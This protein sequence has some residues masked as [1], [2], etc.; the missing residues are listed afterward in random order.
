MQHG[1]API[2]NLSMLNNTKY[3][4]LL[5]SSSSTAIAE[6]LDAHQLK[7]KFPGEHI[8]LV[9]SESRDII[10][11]L[12]I[13][14]QVH[15]ID[16]EF[17][18]KSAFSPLLGDATSFKVL[19][20]TLMPLVQEKWARIFNLSCERL[21]TSVASLFGNTPVL[22]A[23]R[24]ENITL[25]HES[26]LK[27]SSLLNQWGMSHSLID[28]FLYRKAL[29]QID[30]SAVET[31][32]KK[33]YGY[34]SAHSRGDLKA[35]LV[36]MSLSNNNPDDRASIE[37]IGQLFTLISL[38]TKTSDILENYGL[39]YIDWSDTNPDLELFL[40]MNVTDSIQMAKDW[41][42]SLNIS[43]KDPDELTEKIAGII[44][45]NFSKWACLSFLFDYLGY[46][47]LA[48]GSEQMITR[49]DKN[50]LAP[51]LHQDVLALKGF[52]KILLEGL[53]RQGLTNNNL[54]A[55]YWSQNPGTLSFICAIELSLQPS[56]DPLFRNDHDVMAIK[57]RL[58]SLNHFFEKMH[59]ACT[60]EMPT[61]DLA[62]TL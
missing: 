10:L 22:G 16:I 39:N 29:N 6:G 25:C 13:F 12:G 34:K 38:D 27:L 41:D 35:I 49:Y 62:L 51:F 3:L 26:P 58:R 9:R 8:A 30:I 36:G 31:F 48:H 60:L 24:K 44:P 32:L 21:E 14:H 11:A 59:K 42:R 50:S 43:G 55:D 18:Q 54:L 5:L 46:A 37:F 53:R 33:V 57:N 2:G 40:D 56:L 17:M 45:S 19:W 20:N 23:C 7:R 28:Q 1:F 15:E 4:H 47:K 61:T 52:A